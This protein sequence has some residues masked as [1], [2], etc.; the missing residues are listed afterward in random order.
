MRISLPVLFSGGTLAIADDFICD[1]GLPS[2]VQLDAKNQLFNKGG[3]QGLFKSSHGAIVE[4]HARMVNQD[5]MVRRYQVNTAK[6]NDF[7]PTQA[8]E[9]ILKDIQDGVQIDAVNLS[10]GVPVSFSSIAKSLDIADLHGENLPQ[11]KDEILKR[12]DEVDFSSEKE[13][14]ETFGIENYAE[15]L[16]T[17]IDLVSA[18]SA[19]GTPVF[20]SAGNSKKGSLNMLLLADGVMG[21]G[22]S[23]KGEPIHY[24]GANALV[25]LWRNVAQSVQPV[26]EA[27]KQFV[28]LMFGDSKSA[29]AIHLDAADIVNREPGI[30]LSEYMASGF[31][32]IPQ[33]GSSVA[34]PQAASEYVDMVTK[35]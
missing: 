8:L 24:S 21:V 9:N 10:M 11:Y 15:Y 20:V 13:F 34:A 2:S 26:F 6:V 25:T 3:L 23:Y 17:L 1:P 7:E 32:F 35:K 27:G 4:A 29:P 16:K 30:T 33:H 5:V 12:L 28:G 31:Q 14:C 22:A 18:I 19:T